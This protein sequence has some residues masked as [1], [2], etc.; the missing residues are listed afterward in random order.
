MNEQEKW[1][2]RFV[3]EL[4]AE[5]L[6][7][8]DGTSTSVWIARGAANANVPEVPAHPKSVIGIRDILGVQEGYSTVDVCRELMARLETQEQTIGKY[9]A[10]VRGLVTQIQVLEGDIDQKN[11]ERDEI[12]RAVCPD[13]EDRHLD[14]MDQD[15]LLDAIKSLHGRLS[16][17]SVGR[18]GFF[19]PP[20]VKL[21]GLPDTTSYGEILE[22][23]MNQAVKLE[24]ITQSAP[25]R[26][27]DKVRLKGLTV[28]AVNAD[29]CDFSIAGDRGA[30]LRVFGSAIEGRLLPGGK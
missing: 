20:L 21:L 13:T 17:S 24:P 25:L 11:A 1:A 23:V 12:L 14:Q 7:R 18:E 4:Y 10:E 22:A 3:D 16:A 2:K 29:T 30:C 6:R 28:T 27:G 15:D 19:L 26:I 5:M 8:S 9:Q